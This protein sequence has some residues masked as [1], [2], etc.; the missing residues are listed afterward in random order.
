MDR[1]IDFQPHVLIIGSGGGGLAAALSI[2]QNFPH[3]N[4]LVLAEGDPRKANTFYAQG[5]I[6]IAID[7]T[8]SPYQ[9]VR[10]T[11]IAGDG[12]SSPAATHFFASKASEAIQWLIS[13]GMS[14]DKTKTGQLSLG[15]EG[16]H[17][18]NRIIHVKDHT[19]RDVV[20]FLLSHLQKHKKRVRVLYNF[21]VYEI[22]KSYSE[23]HIKSVSLDNGQVYSITVPLVV[24]ATGG[25][26]YLWRFTSNSPLAIGSGLYLASQLNVP[27]KDIEFI[28]FHPT[29]LYLPESPTQPL[30]TEALRGARAVLRNSYGKRFMPEYDERGDLAPRDI[31]ARSIY[32]E[33]KK[34]GIPHVWL[35]ATSVKDWER[36]PT[37]LETCLKHGIDPRKEWIPVVPAAHYQCGGVSVDV[38]GRTAIQGLL[39]IGEVAATGL[40]G[41]NRLASNSLLELIVQAHNLPNVVDDNLSRGEFVASDKKFSVDKPSVIFEDRLRQ[42][43]HEKVG[44]VRKGDELEE[45]LEWINNQKEAIP[46]E[47]N[48]H[49]Q[50]QAIM[51]DVAKLIVL[52]SIN[53]K[54]N[55]GTFYRSDAQKN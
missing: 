26:G 18:R 35:D 32:F 47:D 44:V 22:D 23:F 55:K 40:H 4:I 33:M 16:G 30:I 50:R 37:V 6:A 5:G 9:H 51:F 11:L 38:Y 39:A 7:P 12:Y 31:V 34:L 13:L 36:F 3:Y 52:R 2:A 28:Q 24:L 29:A 41:A 42:V 19:G 1:Q 8:D 46:E 21:R 54:I 53:R 17:T 10:D 25:S 45:A 20:T 14:F 48:I 49:V 27:I 43:M 15:R